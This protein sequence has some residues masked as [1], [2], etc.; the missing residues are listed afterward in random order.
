LNFNGKLGKTLFK[1]RRG[2]PGG[3]PGIGK[4]FPGMYGNFF[5]T[6]PKKI[7]GSGKS[8]TTREFVLYKTQK[9]FPGASPP[10][11]PFFP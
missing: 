1:L 2:I 8:G 5:Y 7:P 9:F 3:N 6:K 4:K 10:W 11:T